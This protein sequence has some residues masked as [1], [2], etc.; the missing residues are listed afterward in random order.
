MHR[1][2]V[3]PHHNWQNWSESSPQPHFSW[4]PHSNPGK[5]HLLMLKIIMMKTHG[6]HFHHQSIWLTPWLLIIWIYKARAS[7]TIAI[8]LF[9]VPQSHELMLNVYQWCSWTGDRSNLNGHP[10]IEAKFQYA[11]WNFVIRELLQL[12]NIIFLSQGP[13]F[14]TWTALV[15]IK[16]YDLIRI[17]NLFT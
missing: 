5:P 11:V 3:T 16:R 14:I 9:M 8:S 10:V 6:R 1:R 17:Q 13:W 4:E 12:T 15:F 7:P 2:W